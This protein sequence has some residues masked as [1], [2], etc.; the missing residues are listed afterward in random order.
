MI[1]PLN[2]C[3]DAMMQS[4]AAVRSGILQSRP[5]HWLPLTSQEGASGMTPLRLLADLVTDVWYR[6]GQDGRETR[7][8]H[9]LVLAGDTLIAQIRNANQCKDEFRNA[10]NRVQEQLDKADFNDHLSGLGKRHT[11]L[12]ESL[13]FS[14]LSRLHLKQCY[15]HL[16]LLEQP[17]LQVGFSWY[18]H[19]R[20]IRRIRTEEARQKLLAL[21]E[22][23]PHIR[24]QLAKLNALPA[25]QPLAQVQTLAPV[26]R[27]N[28]LYPDD[29]PRRRQ[30]M[31]V[32][33]P[34][35]IPGEVLPAFNEIPPQPPEERTRQRRSD[36]K[37]S[38]EPYLPSIRVH[39]YQG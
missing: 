14:G 5:P 19:G 3:F 10:V 31:N 22:D 32:A 12:R 16:P 4:L 7:S 13:H 37:I 35:M 39:L 1:L 38:D 15:R 18:A 11:S 2:D 33:L 23:K 17:P 25:T 36:Q 29:A 8:R 24:I 34:L 28:L 30:A 21:G 6:D 20:S 27:A 26:V 9:G